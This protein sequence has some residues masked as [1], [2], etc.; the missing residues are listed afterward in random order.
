LLE[1]LV[2]LAIVGFPVG[3]VAP[4]FHRLFGSGKPARAARICI[5]RIQPYVISRIPTAASRSSRTARNADMSPSRTPQTSPTTP[6]ISRPARTWCAAMLPGSRRP[7]VREA[8][9]RSAAPDVTGPTSRS[10]SSAGSA[11]SP[12]RRSDGVMLSVTPFAAALS[13]IAAT[14]SGS[15]SFAVTSEAPALAA[16]IAT[17]PEPAATSRTDRPRTWPGWSSR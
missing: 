7:R 4:A 12:S 9:T 1:L 11:P 17:S 2:R 3:L 15:I 14:A 5:S 8:S 13:A 6:P 10:A 16:A